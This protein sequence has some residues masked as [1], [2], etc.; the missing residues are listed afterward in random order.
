[1]LLR[2]YFVRR[3]CCYNRVNDVMNTTL[4][5]PAWRKDHTKFSK[6]WSPGPET[7]RFIIQKYA[8]LIRLLSFPEVKYAYMTKCQFDLIY[9]T[10]SQIYV[11][12][13]RYRGY[14]FTF[15]RYVIQALAE[16]GCQESSIIFFTSSTKFQRIYL[17]TEHSTLLSV[18]LG[19]QFTKLDQ[20]CV[21]SFKE[22]VW[23]A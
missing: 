2:H 8:D 21:V 4:V 5:W 9:Q 6:D 12:I 10:A 16:I 19:W 11:L 22:M 13:W 7:E 23:V 14:N 20:F 18:R 17:E 1:V 3:P 15:S